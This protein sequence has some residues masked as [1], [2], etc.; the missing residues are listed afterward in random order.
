MAVTLSSNGNILSFADFETS[1]DESLKIQ[2]KNGNYPIHPHT[3]SNDASA[4]GLL[5]EIA[6]V[7]LLYFAFNTVDVTKSM[8]G[9]IYI[10]MYIYLMGLIPE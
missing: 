8:L 1:K 9:H 5:M 10:Y 7:F 2:M 4:E 3:N 6:A